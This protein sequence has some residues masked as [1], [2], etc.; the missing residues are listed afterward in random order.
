MLPEPSVAH[1]TCTPHLLP[2][3]YSEIHMTHLNIDVH[4]PTKSKMYSYIKVTTESINLDL[5]GTG[6]RL[7]MGLTSWWR[8]ICSIVYYNNIINQCSLHI[9][10][11]VTMPEVHHNLVKHGTRW[12]KKVKNLS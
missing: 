1:E 8:Y 5:L 12:A 9:T 3:A 7:R 4:K 11:S 10:H 6:L 2:S